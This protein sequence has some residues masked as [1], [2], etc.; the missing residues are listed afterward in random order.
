MALRA[1]AL[2]CGAILLSTLLACAAG[3][4]SAPSS[5]SGSNRPLRKAL[6]EPLIFEIETPK[7]P[8]AIE[9]CL[10]PELRQRQ[11]NVE[12]HPYRI[13]LGAATAREFE[14]LVKA[15][16]TDVTVTFDRQCGVRTGLP[17]ITT[18]IHSANRELYS[19]VED[20]LQ[21]TAITLITSVHGARGQRAWIE[22][23]E[24]VVSAPPILGG[25]GSSGE[26]SGLV[27]ILFPHTIAVKDL[28]HAQASREFGR[29]I[30]QALR[31]IERTIRR[32]DELPALLSPGHGV[33]LESET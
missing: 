24:S 12:D 21:Y 1:Y 33:E 10:S 28:R 9:L 13:D 29:A 30:E 14:R 18:E 31:E 23:T 8:E 7:H 2:L 19:E 5:R 25:L 20:D 4:S 16:F 3:P 15:T 22:T 11:W 6:V 26:R 17:W 32:S 27:S